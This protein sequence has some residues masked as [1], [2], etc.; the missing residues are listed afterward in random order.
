MVGTPEILECPMVDSKFPG[1]SSM[2]S[3]SENGGDGVNY[4]GHFQTDTVFPSYDAT[5]QW[6]KEIS[7]PIGFIFVSSSYKTT[8]DGRSF[9]YLACD[10]GR[11][12]R[13]RD[14][15]NVIRKDTKTKSVGCPFF[16]KIYY[17][18][19]TDGWRI[20]AKNDVTGTHNH[21]FIVYPEGHRQISGL[22][23]GAKQVVRNLMR[24]KVASRNIMSTIIEQ[25]PEDHP[26]IMHIYN[27][28]S[29]I[30]MDDSE[31]RGV[32]QQLLHL[33]R[34]SHYL[35]WVMADDIG[36]LQH[37]FMV[38]PITCNLLHTYP[39]VIGMDSTYKT[40]IYDMPFFEIVGRLRD[41][42]GYQR[43]PSV[44]LTDRELGLCASLKAEF[45][46]LTH[47]LCR[48]HINKDVEAYVTGLFKD[49]TVGAK[50]KN[51]RWKRV[52]DAA[53][54]PEYELALQR[55]KTSW[56]DIRKVESQHSA[57]KSWIESSTGS[58]D[59]VWAR[60]HCQIGNQIVGIRNALEASRSKVGEK[61]RHMPL[62]RLNGKVSHYCLSVL[63]D[64]TERLRELS[65][66]VHVRCRCA[67]WITNGIPCA[68]QIYDSMRDK[69]W[70]YCSQIHPFWQ[71][72]VIGDDVDI[73]E[74]VNESAEEE[75]HFRSLVNEV[76]ASDPVTIWNVSRIIED[77]LHPNHSNIEEPEVNH[78]TRGRPQDR[79][80][81]RDCSHFENVERNTSGRGGRRSRQ[82]NSRY[83][84]LLLGPILPYINGWN[85][86]IGD[87][88]CGFRCIASCFMGDQEQWRLARQIMANEIT[89]YP[90]YTGGFIMS[91]GGL[92]FEIQ[93]IRWSGGTCGER[94]WMV[95]F[96]DLYVIATLYNATVICYGIGLTPT[97]YYPCIIVLPL[98]APDNA[99]APAREFVIGTVG[100]SHF[101]LLQLDQDHPIPPIA[102]VWYR[103]R[104]PSVIGWEQ[105]YQCRI[106]L[107]ERLV[108]S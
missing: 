68:C 65:C 89:G 60:V 44:F 16:I 106:S 82:H 11:K 4:S 9:R 61:Y 5:V 67:L 42:I 66:E 39:Y 51:G 92:N 13:P 47:L 3:E 80:T 73:P 62:Q 22:S 71:S 102:D 45:P 77:E 20:C 95:A 41:L 104:E 98:Q 94:H 33:A 97:S 79:S 70:L 53:S 48:W 100:G 27:S 17:E 96:Q 72:L 24:S 34:E 6:A 23:P 81:K 93:R 12:K 69:K 57:V 108:A 26:N 25:F 49:K 7:R 28:R 8:T 36:V 38:H 64:E 30:R 74:F 101:I 29:D 46:H 50:F 18:R 76:L 83:A 86:V 56:V 107:W 85:D 1:V 59:T 2:D 52:M 21:P 55:L 87:G 88:N 99:T 10:R 40:N 84:H 90:P 32:V 78:S 37:A 14:L 31:G 19:S 63:Y 105:R 15:E 58:L 75:T 43:E 54:E 103:A 35:Y 91:Q